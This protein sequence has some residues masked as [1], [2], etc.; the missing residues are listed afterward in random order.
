MATLRPLFFGGVG[1]GTT[2]VGGTTLVEGFQVLLE[3]CLE[4]TLDDEIEVVMEIEELD[5]VLDDDLG[6]VE[7]CD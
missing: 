7:I 6:E 3:E 2:I 4:A 1:G 5:A